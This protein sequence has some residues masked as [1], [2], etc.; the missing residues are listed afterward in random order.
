LWR[1]TPQWSQ[2]EQTAS[3]GRFDPRPVL[4]IHFPGQSS[5]QDVTQ[6]FD[7]GKVHGIIERMLRGQDP[8]FDK[9][10]LA[11]GGGSPL[12]ATQ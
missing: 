8:A 5:Q 12:A 10:L 6:P 9:A 4:L 2:E 7:E 1:P 11:G 3:Q